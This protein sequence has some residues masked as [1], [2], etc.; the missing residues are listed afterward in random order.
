M[1]IEPIANWTFL[2]NHTHVL[3]VIAE[4]PD[5][6]LRDVAEQVG[7]TERGA[8]RI[9][10]DLVDAGYLDARRVGRRNHYELRLREPLRHPLEERHTVGELVELLRREATVEP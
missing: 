7:I 10:R 4:E 1:Y 5:I 6:R 3:L 2:T 9:V 8:Q